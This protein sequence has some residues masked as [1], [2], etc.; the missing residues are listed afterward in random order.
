M[1]QGRL[2]AQC[3][4][5]AQKVEVGVATRMRI[6]DCGK[7]TREIVTVATAVN[8][9]ESE[10]NCERSLRRTDEFA[11]APKLTINRGFTPGGNRIQEGFA[12]FFKINSGR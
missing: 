3:L 1:K 6:D 9:R 2:L 11:V 5:L 4:F 7:V 10:R 8:Q 12:I